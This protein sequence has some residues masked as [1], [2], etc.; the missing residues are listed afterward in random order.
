MSKRKREEQSAVTWQARLDAFDTPQACIE[1]YTNQLDDCLHDTYLIQLLIDLRVPIDVLKLAM[2]AGA[3]YDTLYLHSLGLSLLEY[4][5][6]SYI[7]HF[8]LLAIEVGRPYIHDPVFGYYVVYVRKLAH[9]QGL[10]TDRFIQ[11]VLAELQTVVEEPTHLPFDL[12]NKST[13]AE[14]V[15]PYKNQSMFLHLSMFIRLLTDEGYV[16]SLMLIV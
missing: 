6:R 15:R 9:Q 7:P 11:H 13:V 10:H 1:Y 4:A 5:A 14:W 3:T 2:S 8:T 12:D 16:E